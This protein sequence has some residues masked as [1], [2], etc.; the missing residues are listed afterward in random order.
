[1]ASSGTTP[2]LPATQADDL[3]EPIKVTILDVPKFFLDS[4][5]TRW[6]SRVKN[7][8]KPRMLENLIDPSRPRPASPQPMLRWRFWSFTVHGWLFNQLDDQ[9]IDLINNLPTESTYADDL[10]IEIHKLPVGDPEE[11]AKKATCDLFT[12]RRSG[13]TTAVEY[14]EAWQYQNSICAGL[15]VGITPYMA[16]V[17]MLHQLEEELP[18]TVGFLH[19]RL[20]MKAG[21]AVNMDKR[22]F[23]DLCDTLL[24][25][26]KALPAHPGS[27]IS[28]KASTSRTEKK[29]KINKDP[30]ASPDQN[31]KGE[32]AK[33]QIRRVPPKEK[34]HTEYAR[35]WRRHNLQRDQ[36]DNCFYCNR[37]NHGC[38]TCFLS[39]RAQAFRVGSRSIA[40]VLELPEHEEQSA[41]TARSKKNTE[42]K[43]GNTT[44]AL[45][46]T[47]HAFAT[48]GRNT[49][50]NIQRVSLRRLGLPSAKDASPKEAEDLWL[51]LV[52][53]NFE[54][55]EGMLDKLSTLP[56][57]TLSE[58]RHLRVGGSPLMLQPIDY[59]DDVYC[60]LVWALKLLPG[61]RL[62][63]LT[64]LGPSDGRLAYDTLDRLI[65][66]G[67]RWR[68]LH[69]LTPNSQM[70]CFAKDDFL[71]GS[72]ILAKTSTKQLEYHPSQARCHQPGYSPSQQKVAPQNQA[73]FRV[74]EDRDL[75]SRSEARKEVLV[76]AKRGR[77]AHIAEQ[78]SPPYLFND[79]RQW[80]DGL[81][82]AKFRRLQYGSF[83]GDED[84]DD[85]DD[86]V[87]RDQDV[88]ADRYDVV[89]EYSWNPVN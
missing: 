44:H 72:S 76:V 73:D 52:L 85:D 38:A 79:I 48:S 84:E 68:E 80:A 56:L 31:P 17:V 2:L 18:K 75:S 35:E 81:T 53:F 5:I 41:F 13:F 83:S 23:L 67:N 37:P 61:L 54:D 46:S 43:D 66:Y 65:E 34:N 32:I 24:N 71:P 29:N 40:L 9:I 59:D 27:N 14:I 36:D 7:S 62:D 12:I 87:E 74:A 4:N 30:K 42:A 11:H 16:T 22:E 51:G 49:Q 28:A 55:A 88:Q 39:P 64:V 70:L 3:P 45:R 15:K 10:W 25:N 50:S 21:D 89:D 57:S 63:K 1:M 58:I 47:Q 69:F 86:L 60:R 77:H 78:V 20:S 26:A 19:G 8:L 6:G 82:W 33:K